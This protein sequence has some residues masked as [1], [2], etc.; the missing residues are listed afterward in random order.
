MAFLISEGDMPHIYTQN[1]IQLR[2][3]ITLKLLVPILAILFSL[4][5]VAEVYRPTA[6]Q[7]VAS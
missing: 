5:S 7:V 1:F 2:N 6:N 3:S 4:N